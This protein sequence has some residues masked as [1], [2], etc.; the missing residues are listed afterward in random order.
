MLFTKLVV[1]NFIYHLLM[2]VILHSQSEVYFNMLIIQHFPI[3]GV[4]K[5]KMVQDCPR[6]KYSKR[7]LNLILSSK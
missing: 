5:H 1:C 7:W 6:S 2:L 4:L 3:K